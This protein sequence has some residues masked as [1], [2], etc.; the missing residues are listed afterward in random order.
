M[1]VNSLFQYTFA[2]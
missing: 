2:F 1:Y